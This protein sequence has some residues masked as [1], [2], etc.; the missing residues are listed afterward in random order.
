SDIFRRRKPLVLLGYGLAAL[1]KIVFP[2]APSLG[3]V[4]TAR[5]A[6]RVGKGIRGAPC[7][8]LI[9]DLA[10]ADVRGASF[11]LRQALDTVGAF[12]GPLLALAAMAYFHS[13]FRA[14]FWVA[15]VPAFIAV[16]LLTFGVD[17]PPHAHSA[18][19]K[20][21]VRLDLHAIKRLGRAYAIVV[22]IAA[23]L[24]LA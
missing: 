17:E 24:T 6:D 1:T 9:A 11:G 14:T 3:W 19:D 2:L 8:A 20:S 21:R 23:I 13:D 4:V 7:D 18:D 12:A 10:P 15:V 22:V 5:F 16:A